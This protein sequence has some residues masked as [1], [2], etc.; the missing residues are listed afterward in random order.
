VPPSYQRPTQGG[1][2]GGRILV[3][4]AAT[5]REEEKRSPLLTTMG[6]KGGGGPIVF[7]CKCGDPQGGGEEI[8]ALKYEPLREEEE[9]FASVWTVWPELGAVT[10]GRRRDVT[11][12]PETPG[13]RRGASEPLFLVRVVDVLVCDRPDLSAAQAKV[14]QFSV[15]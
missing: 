2:E 10:S 11:A 5:S 13:R 1:G 14:T 12:V 8:A 7:C 15:A 9:K 3:K 6:T 4:D